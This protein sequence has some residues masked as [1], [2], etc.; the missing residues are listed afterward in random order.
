MNFKGDRC[1][2]EKKLG[3]LLKVECVKCLKC[4]GYGYF[5]VICFKKEVMIFKIF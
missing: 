1:K 5:R 2:V 3:E 4:H